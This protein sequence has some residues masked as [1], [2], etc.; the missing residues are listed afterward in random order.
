MTG[1]LEQRTAWVV[2]QSAAATGFGQVVKAI[3]AQ[4]RDADEMVAVCLPG[5]SREEMDRVRAMGFDVV[6]S[7][8]SSR[9]VGEVVNSAIRASRAEILV[10]ASTS[11]LPLGRHFFSDIVDA[12]EK[13]RGV[14]AVRCLRGDDR[15]RLM[16]W[17]NMDDPVSSIQDLERAVL[18]APNIA[19]FGIRRSAW[20]ECG[21]D[22]TREISVDKIWAYFAI[23][24]GHAVMA[25]HAMF[26]ELAKPGLLEAF[27]QR[28][29]QSVEFHLATGEYVRHVQPSIVAAL[30]GVAIVGPRLAVRHAVGT[31]L[32]FVADTLSHWSVW[33]ARRRSAVDPQSDGVHV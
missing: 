18:A 4:D 27:R 30:R 10:V 7:C 12:F 28:R 13:H 26:L 3:R 24:R 17:M 8:C 14:A 5:A 9:A 6:V 22:E 11:V 19:C 23:H 21:F 29:R 15:S 1:G 20:A 2:Y 25:S 31:V 16:Q 32:T 33:S